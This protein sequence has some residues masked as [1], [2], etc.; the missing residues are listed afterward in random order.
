MKCSICE[1]EIT[2]DPFG[3]KGGCNAE[4]I[5]D[6]KCCYQ[7]DINVVL[8]ARLIEHGFKDDEIQEVLELKKKE[9]KRWDS[10]CTD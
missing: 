2:T 10:I 1:E 6:G 7:C 4:P 5:N 8:P 3:W 9:A